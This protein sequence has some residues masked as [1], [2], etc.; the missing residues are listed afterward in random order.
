[1]LPDIIPAIL[2]T[3]PEDLESQARALPAEIT[4]FHLDVLDL[5]GGGDIWAPFKQDFEAHLMVENPAA[6]V[7]RWVERGAKRL[8]VHKIDSE[9]LKY[10]DKVEIGLA[11]ELDV[12]IKDVLVLAEL[13]DFVHVMSISEIGAQGHPLDTR[14]F[15]RI[16]AVQEKFPD[17]P[18]SVD[19][20]VTAQNYERLI[21]AGADRLV[22]GSHFKEIWENLQKKS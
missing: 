3:T 20:G 15:D 8:I 21:E 6:I 5:P 16:K 22:V 18:I 12:A 13:S 9:I 17:L 4:H 11:F 19:G 1:M 10:R 2:P 7:A 14:V